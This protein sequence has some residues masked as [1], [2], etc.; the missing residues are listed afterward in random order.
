MTNFLSGPDYSLEQ[1]YEQLNNRID[2]GILQLREIFQYLRA[3][4]PDLSAIKITYEG[5][6]D[7]G[8]VEDIQYE[9]T[10]LKDGYVHVDDSEELPDELAM[11]RKSRAGHW[12]MD[13]RKWITKHP[14]RNESIAEALDRTG[15]DIAYGKNPGFEN[16]QGGFGTLSISIDLSDTAS[17]P[18]ITLEHSERVETTNDYVYNL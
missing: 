18:E 5:I 16:N 13:T 4:Y 10:N 3:K 2:Q 15:W 11:G 7:S 14:D 8:Q 9:S 1:Y 17:E 6:A 12:C